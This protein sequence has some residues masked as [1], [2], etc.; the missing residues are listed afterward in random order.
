[1]LTIST[2]EKGIP[3]ITSVLAGHEKKKKKKVKDIQMITV[4]CG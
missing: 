2:E 4:N 3:V 1:M